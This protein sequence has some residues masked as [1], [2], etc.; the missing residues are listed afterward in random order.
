M[1]RRIRQ[2]GFSL[3]ELLIVIAMLLV[4]SAIVLPSLKSTFGALQGTWAVR[5]ISSELYLARMRAG[6]KFTK[7]RVHID[8]SKRT[9]Q[10]EVSDKTSSTCCYQVE[11]GTQYLGGRVS[12]G[13]G[14]IATAAGGQTSIAQSAAVTFNSRGIPVTES[15]IP[16]EDYAIYLNNSGHF[17]AVTVSIAGQVETWRW[18]GTKWEAL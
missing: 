8:N 5:G 11:G 18:S 12:Y 16:T 7:T 15:G 6:A 10:L 4:V 2:T 14:S 3:V 17:Y 13:F 9:F 1:L